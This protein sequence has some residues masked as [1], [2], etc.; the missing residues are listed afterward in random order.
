MFVR[1]IELA[2]VPVYLIAWCVL[3]VEPRTLVFAGEALEDCAG[4]RFNH[5]GSSYPKS[6]VKLIGAEIAAGWRRQFQDAML[7]VSLGSPCRSCSSSSPG[8][9]VRS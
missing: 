9:F 5:C 1:V 8:D 7:R 6:R 2:E 4:L 3:G